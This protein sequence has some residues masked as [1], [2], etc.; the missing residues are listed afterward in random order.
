MAWSQG[1][2]TLM[3]SIPNPDIR[4]FDYNTGKNVVYMEGSRYGNGTAYAIMETGGQ[5]SLYG[6]KFITASPVGRFEQSYYAELNI[7]DFNKATSFA[8]HSTLPYMFYSIENKIYQFDIVNK[9]VKLMKTLENENVTLLK[10]PLF[11]DAYYANFGVTKTQ[12]YLNQQYD[13]IVGSSHTS[14][15]EK[16]RGKLRFYSVPPLNG[17]LSLIKEY[18]GFADIVDVTYRE[19]R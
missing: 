8:F 15:P 2:A 12:E 14:Q 7:P 5:Y 18:S 10:F 3:N 4:L 11:R 17:D 13:L 9:Q 19:A 16:S 1:H 6:I